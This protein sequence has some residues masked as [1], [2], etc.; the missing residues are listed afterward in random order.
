MILNRF[1]DPVC[2][3]CLIGS[4]V[5]LWSRTREVIGSYNPFNYK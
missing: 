1:K 2:Y 5:T 3:Q 4:M